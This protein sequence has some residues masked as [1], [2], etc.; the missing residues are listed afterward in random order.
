MLEKVI[1]D[2]DKV[3][4]LIAEHHWCI[5]E[6]A[7]EAGLS[8]KTITYA[9]RGQRIKLSTAWIIAERLGVPVSE[10]KKETE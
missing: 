7:R 5:T 1:L 3:Y 2:G 8:P 6:L 9:V 4:N 10:L